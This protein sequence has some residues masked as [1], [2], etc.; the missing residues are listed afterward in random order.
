[1]CAVFL[2]GY[3]LVLLAAES[4]GG[5]K[6]RLLSPTGGCVYRGLGGNTKLPH[7]GWGLTVQVGY[8][9]YAF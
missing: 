4:F 2:G 1:M 7:T 3:P 5:P 8:K 6:R 9:P